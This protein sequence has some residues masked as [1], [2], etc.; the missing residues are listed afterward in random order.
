MFG[1]NLSISLNKFPP[2]PPESEFSGGGENLLSTPNL[3]D[4]GSP[5][6]VKSEPFLDHFLRILGAFRIQTDSFLDHFLTKTLVG[7]KLVK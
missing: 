3:A 6:I 5:K 1:H 2:P 4:L 7:G